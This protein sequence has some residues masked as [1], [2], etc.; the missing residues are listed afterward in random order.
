MKISNYLA[1][2]FT[3]SML[4]FS[5]TVLLSLFLL[6]QPTALWA[7]GAQVESKN[8]TVERRGVLQK[9]EDSAITFR[10]SNQIDFNEDV[11]K[12]AEIN[13]TTVNGIVLLSGSVATA[14]GKS[15]C[16]EVAKS[17][18]KVQKVINELKVRKV[19]SAFALARDKAL[20]IAVK[21][22]LVGELDEEN[23]TVHVV[24]YDKVVYLMGVVSR[25]VAERAT[26]VAR[27]VKRIDRV[28]TIFQFKE[29]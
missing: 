10:V 17:H 11:S 9:M 14:Q 12:S 19:R 29:E 21:I 15:W 13:V 3:G 4:M 26:K 25:D 7:Q 5:K 8:P 16:E 20:Q 22:R 2:N 24:I 28:I 18:P 1:E 6:M 23:P 27:Q